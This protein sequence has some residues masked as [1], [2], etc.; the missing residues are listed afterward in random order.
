M[1]VLFLLAT[2]QVRGRSRGRARARGRGRARGRARAGVR[3]RPRARATA[4]VSVR[5]WARVRVRVAAG[6][7]V[8]AVERHRDVVVPMEEDH[9]RLAQGEPQRV[10]Q[11]KDLGVD[12]KRDEEADPAG[13]VAC[14]VA[15]DRGGEAALG[16]AE[17]AEE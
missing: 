1:L 11:L 17:L 2:T 13:A 14:G 4:R 5:V 7:R 16:H 10:H 9:G 12:E 8:R 15:A 6:V 3:V